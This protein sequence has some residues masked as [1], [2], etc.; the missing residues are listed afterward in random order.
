M[1]EEVIAQKETLKPKQNETFEII[2]IGSGPAGMSAAVCAKRAS[3]K[4]LMI[5]K[6]FPGGQL[7]TAYEISNYIGF[8]NP[9]GEDIASKMEDHILD[10]EIYYSCET[11]EDIIDIKGKV[12]T[13]LTDLGNKYKANAIIIASGL[14]PKLLNTEFEK[15]FLGRGISYY[16]Q[17]DIDTYKNEEVAVIGGGNCACYAANYLAKH[18]KQLY[19]IHQSDHLKAVKSLK[20]KVLSDEKIK[21]LWNSE[22]TEVFGID[23]VEKAKVRNISNNQSTWIDIKCIFIYAGRVP[24]ENILN[25][26]LEV[27]E[28]GFIITDEMMRTNIDG[29]YA[30]G[31]IRVK[32]IR[33]IATAISD[34]MIAAINIERDLFR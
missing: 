33:Q 23:K 11:V 5:D 14:E 27:D 29:V 1:I 7:S 22:L 17:S 8:K 28:D 12:K 34:G 2:I 16:A 3:F 32:Q 10:L 19:L 24:S 26:E 9:L 20:E 31:D 15:N 18:V 13:V 6:A 4:V 30:A 21:L 25:I